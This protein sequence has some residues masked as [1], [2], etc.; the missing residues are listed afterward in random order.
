MSV[1]PFSSR[2]VKPMAEDAVAEVFA[3]SWGALDAGRVEHPGAYLRRGVVNELRRQARRRVFERVAVRPSGRVDE[4][5]DTVVVDRDR[6][7]VALRNLP[8]RQREVL[9]L[10]FWEDR[11]VTETADLLGMSA[12]S[13]K[14]H[15][16]RGLEAIRRHVEDR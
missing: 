14:T 4:G 6:L 11:S 5:F 16:H 7:L 15:T 10:R 8:R 12:G 13:V 1:R 2:V 9:V 3:R